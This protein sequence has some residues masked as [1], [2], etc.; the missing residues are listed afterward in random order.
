MTPQTPDEADRYLLAGG[1]R[2]GSGA[3]AAPLPPSDILSIPAPSLRV[4][5]I[6]NAYGFLPRLF[7]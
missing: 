6:I 4:F 5:F 3:L 7:V 1:K 2:V